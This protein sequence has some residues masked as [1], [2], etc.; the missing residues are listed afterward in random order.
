M[1]QP[2]TERFSPNAARVMRQAQIE[3]RSMNHDHVGTEHL[4]LG[5]IAVEECAASKILKSLNTSTEDLRIR[6]EAQTSNGGVVAENQP[7]Q[8][9]WSQRALKVYDMALLVAESRGCKLVNSACLLFAI[10]SEGEGLGALILLQLGIT[11]DR[12]EQFM[13]QTD[14]TDV[15]HKPFTS[16]T[17]GIPKAEFPSPPQGAAQPLPEGKSPTPALDTFGRDLTILATKGKLDPVIGRSGELHRLI[18]ILCRRSKNNAVLIGEAGVGKTAVVEGLAQAIIA[19]EVP[20]SMLGKHLISLDMA[21]LVAGTQYRGQFEERL[22]RVIDEVA[23]SGKVILFLDELH[24]IVG[25]GGSEGAMDAANIIKPALA[26]GELQCIGATTLD[27][28]RKGIEKDAALERRFQTIMVEEPTVDQAIEILKGI[29]PRYEAHHGVHYTPAALEAAA[30]LTARYQSA[31]QLPDK[32]IDAIDETGS[33]LRLSAAMRPPAL[34]KLENEV[35]SLRKEKEAAI[36]KDNYDH[37]AKL[38]T[39][40]TAKAEIFEKKLL[41][42]QSQQRAQPITVDSDAIAQ[43]I[44]DMTG[45][46]VYQMTE[47]DRRRVAGLEAE[48]EE[49]VIG[50]HTAVAAVSRAIR[51]A[52]AGMKDPVRPI[53]SFLFLGPSGVG[54]TLLAKELARSIFGDAKALIQLDMSEYME[55]HTV[56]RLVGS[57]PGYV[58]HEEGGQLTEKVRRRPYSVVLFDEIEKAHPDITNMLLQI[59]EEGCLTDGLGR[60]VDFRNTIIILTSNIGCNFAAE[61][62]TVGFMPGEDSKGVLMAHDALTK[63]ITA[64]VK[65]TLKPELLNRFDEMIVF[66]ALD[67]TSIESILRLEL[68]TVRKRLAS[69]GVHFELDDSAMTLLADEGC[70]PEQGARPLR[71]AI[72]RLVEDPLADFILRDGTIKGLITLTADAEKKN[73]VVSLKVLP[74]PQKKV[75]RKSPPRT[76]SSARKTQTI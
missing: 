25:A 63:K 53:G 71:R 67:R 28:Y 21:L 50:Q 19:G 1:D 32:A 18:Q 24:T 74:V 55:K 70:R 69:A 34:R 58:G 57:P 52:R 41:Q 22:K 65:K 8:L 62:P 14:A 9:P 13:P 61:A 10:V 76:R 43:T 38:R 27:E 45:V 36:A 42:W 4:M 72:E 12:L 23:R 66:H 56:S 11:T 47:G 48:L 20:E 3:A 2:N 17:D 44:A 26:R 5:C 68:A 29:A 75:T 15:A 33:Q 7:G 16:P 40:E 54:K 51:R 73:L 39:K 60:H 49:K 31:R 59:F 64:E 30:R 46:P 35:K 37:A 6:I